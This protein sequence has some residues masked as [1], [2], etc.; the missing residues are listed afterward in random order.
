M[1]SSKVRSDG[2]GGHMPFSGMPGSHAAAEAALKYETM[3]SKKE[4]KDANYALQRLQEMAN[5]RSMQRRAGE[6]ADDDGPVT[7]DNVV[8]RWEEVNKQYAEIKAM[9]PPPGSM[10]AKKVLQLEIAMNTLELY[11]TGELAKRAALAEGKSIEAARERG[12]IAVRSMRKAVKLAEESK[13]Q[14]QA[15]S[16][17]GGNRTVRRA[18]T[19]S[20]P[21]T[22]RNTKFK[23]FREEME[24][25]QAEFCAADKIFGLSHCA[26]VK[27]GRVCDPGTNV[28]DFCGMH[29]PDT[30]HPKRCEEGCSECDTEAAALSN[31]DTLRRADGSLMRAKCTSCGLSASWNGRTGELCDAA[32]G[33]KPHTYNKHPVPA[34]YMGTANNDEE[35]LRAAQLSGAGTIDMWRSNMCTQRNGSEEEEKALAERLEMLQTAR[36]PAAQVR[37]CCYGS[38]ELPCTLQVFS[39]EGG[40]VGFCGAEHMMQA[41]APRD[42]PTK[43]QPED[44]DHDQ[45][46]G[47][48]GG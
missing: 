11:G 35:A 23:A 48:G 13:A 40:H 46:G 34:T 9:N 37:V 15:D 6:L 32:C 28:C 41:T 19:S 14:R 26:H 10:M 39:A 17:A 25:Q 20:L 45:A 24:K 30:W 22:L 36:Q 21:A 29:E 42:T 4:V 3:P 5:H 38:G 1:Q 44:G 2:H 12:N 33:V 7:A 16:E 43:Q 18:N 27:C 47:G 8:Q 31:E